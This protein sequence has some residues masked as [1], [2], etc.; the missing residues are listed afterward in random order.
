MKRQI[1]TLR[2]SKL[3]PA[4]RE[5]FD[6]IPD[7]RNSD[8][9]ALSYTVSEVLM[10]SLAM[11]TVQDPSMLEFQKRLN[12]SFGTNNLK[13]LFTVDNIPAAS[14]FRR[15]LDPLDPSLIQEAFVPCLRRLQR[16]RIWSD[17]RVLNG[18]YAVLIDGSEFYRSNKCGCKNCRRYKHRDGSVSYAHQVLAATLASY[19]KKTNISIA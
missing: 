6:R 9:E 1:N 2:L 11:M 3:I 8:S 13:T 14:Q 7:D 16:T 12:N 19:G 18:R 4:I 5:V 15:I 17:Y 10:S